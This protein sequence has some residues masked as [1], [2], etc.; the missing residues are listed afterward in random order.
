MRRPCFHTAVVL[1]AVI[2]SGCAL[3]WVFVLFNNTDKPVRV[4]NGAKWFQLDP[5]TFQKISGSVSREVDFIID[6]GTG[7]W[8]YDVFRNP[9][10]KELCSTEG[11]HPSLY[12]QLGSNGVV[13][14]TEPRPNFPVSKLPD[15]PPGFPLAPSPVQ[16]QKDGT[17]I[18]S[19]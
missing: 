8:G 17:F 6:A 16:A 12:F 10:P 11:G 19:P 7:T 5:K 1:I 14:I 3:P 9:I 4:Y 13:Y 18:P 2:V 15:Q